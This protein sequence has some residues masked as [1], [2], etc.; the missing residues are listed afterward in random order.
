MQGRDIVGILLAAGRGTRFDANGRRNKL[1][2]RIDN[3][4]VVALAARSLR[5][6][7]GRVIAVVRVD[8]SDTAAILADEGCTVLPIDSS[9]AGMSVSLRCA[10]EHT[11][12]ADGWVVA[13]GDMPYVRPGTSRALAQ[14]LATGADIAAPYFQG[15]RGNPVAFGRDH[16]AALM[17]LQGDQGARALLAAHP[18]ARVDVDD[19]GIH[20][21][22]DTD[23]DLARPANENQR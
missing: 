17:Q 19:P 18:L 14:A 20:L 5:A 23:A 8:D 7:L 16:F 4:P 3:T 10:L 6:A 11:K 9:D 13:L 22:I 1:L 12:N 15:R 2:A 21:D